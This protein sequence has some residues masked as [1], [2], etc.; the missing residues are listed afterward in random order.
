MMYFSRKHHPR[1]GLGGGHSIHAPG[2]VCKLCSRVDG[3][4]VSESGRAGARGHPG[5]RLPHGDS[6]PGGGVA[7]GGQALVGLRERGAARSV[8][9]VAPG[10]MALSAHPPSGSEEGRNRVGD[11]RHAGPPLRAARGGHRDAPG[12]RGVE[13]RPPRGE[14]GAQVGDARR[15]GHPAVLSAAFRSPPPQRA[16]L[17]AQAGQAEPGTSPL[18]GTQ[19]PSGTGPADGA[20]RGALGSAAAIPPAGRRGLRHARV[21]RGPLPGGACAW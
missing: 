7:V 3:S 6:V 14:S 16:L 20:D 12:R 17:H 15:G 8:A 4:N 21:G 11:R 13:P 18:P 10:P 5:S 19:D 2:G 9:D 1:G